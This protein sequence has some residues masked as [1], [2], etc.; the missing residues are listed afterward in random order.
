MIIAIPKGRLMPLCLGALKKHGV[1][2]KKID[3][4]RKLSYQL[5]NGI[6]IFIVRNS[7]VIT[8]VKE[9]IAD[10]AFIGSDMLLEYQDQG[11][12]YYDY[13]DT[14]LSRC[15]LVLAGRKEDQDKGFGGAGA[16]RGAGAAGGVGGA[17]AGAARGAGGVGGARG[18]GGVGGVGG[19]G[20]RIRVATK[21]ENVAQK[22]YSE[23]GKQADII[24]IRGSVELAAKSGFVE[25]IVDIVDTG[26]TLQ[27][28]NLVPLRKITDVS[29][30]IIVN[31]GIMKSKWRE[32][33]PLAKKL[34][35]S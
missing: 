29:T 25:H 35:G 15:S 31:K 22:F 2:T 8:Y 32:I 34:T 5:D 19:A 23:M 3:K 9:N 33:N 6:S 17:G 12:S 11:K 18:A 28:N 16:A 7:D 27:E 4:S 24:K 26:R 13:G 30:R 10:L 14:K 21:Y 20:G 1:L